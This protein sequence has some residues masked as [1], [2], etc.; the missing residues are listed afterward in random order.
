MNP[1]RSNHHVEHAPA[2]DAG[3]RLSPVLPHT[4]IGLTEAA[5]EEAARL[6]HLTATT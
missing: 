6:P 2:A 1:L 5:L 3:A 4:D